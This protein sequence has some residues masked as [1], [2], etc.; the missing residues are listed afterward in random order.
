MYRKMPRLS[1][2]PFLPRSL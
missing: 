2:L 1:I